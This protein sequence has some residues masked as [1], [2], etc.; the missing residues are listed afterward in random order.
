V[1][2][3]VVVHDSSVDQVSKCGEW[4]RRLGRVTMITTS[5][6]AGPAR[7]G[8]AYRAAR[9]GHC[10]SPAPKPKPWGSILKSPFVSWMVYV[11]E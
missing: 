2:L 6:P 11:V 3:P 8:P 4:S 7:G 9:T 5:R 1:C 10:A